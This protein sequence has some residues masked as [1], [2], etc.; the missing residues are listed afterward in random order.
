MGVSTSYTGGVFNVGG[1]SSVT[2]TVGRSS[3]VD[4]PELP[5]VLQERISEAANRPVSVQV[6]FV[7]YEQASA[8][9]SASRVSVAPAV[10]NGVS[11]APSGVSAA[12]PVPP[13][14][15]TSEIPDGV[16]AGRH[17]DAALAVV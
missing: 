15:D 14:P 9:S 8:G 16:S 17:A 12:P 13:A 11:T 10:L 2:V 3:D 4:Y 1:E 6:R 5:A 7:D